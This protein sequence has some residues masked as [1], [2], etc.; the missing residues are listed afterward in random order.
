MTKKDVKTPGGVTPVDVVQKN[1]PLIKDISKMSK[2]WNKRWPDIDQP[3]PVEGTLNPDVIKTMQVLV[4][5]YKAD[6]KKGKKGEDRKEKRQVE[7]GILKLFE[8]EGQK[9]VKIAKE[10]REKEVEEIEQSINKT[11]KLMEEINAPFSHTDPVKKPTSYDKVVKFKEIYPQL[12]VINQEGRYYITD[13]EECVIESGRADTTIK[14][15]P[16]S[17]RKKKVVCLKTKGGLAA[18]KKEARDDDE[19]SDPEGAIGGYDPVIRWILARAEKRGSKKWGKKQVREE[20]S[21]ESERG[22][23]DEDSDHDGALSSREFSPKIFSTG[24]RG[25]I[26]QSLEEVEESIDECLLNLDEA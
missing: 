6:Q 16:E 11:E 20:S 21:N 13:D 24:Q 15:Y 22:D 25:N 5:T 9:L 23:S 19:Q 14:M 4:S 2:K 10:K 18:G 17:K 7:L 3:W 26:Q 8:Q 12:P 1:N